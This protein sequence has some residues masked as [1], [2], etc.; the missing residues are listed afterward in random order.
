MSF[1]FL[2]GFKDYISN[3]L[4]NDGRYASSFKRRKSGSIIVNYGIVFFLQECH[5]NEVLLSK[6]KSLQIS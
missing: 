4:V 2:N 1:F 5:K 6:L 3:F